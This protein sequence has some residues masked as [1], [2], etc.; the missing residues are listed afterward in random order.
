MVELSRHIDC[1]FD[2][3]HSGYHVAEGE[4]RDFIKQLHCAYGT[5]GKL[6]GIPVPGEFKLDQNL[7]GTSPGPAT[8]LKE[9]CLDAKGRKEYRGGPKRVQGQ[10]LC[11]PQRLVH[12]LGQRARIR[13]REMKRD[14][15]PR[16]R[17]LEPDGPLFVAE[18]FDGVHVG[19]TERRVEAENDADDGGDAE[20]QHGRP[21]R[22]D[23]LHA[24]GVAN[25][26]GNRYAE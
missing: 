15:P 3:G 20:G 12:S 14:L 7:F 21:E 25:D 6:W 5:S 16:G 11:F 10:L 8:Y 19:G 4:R 2:Q 18:G 26:K 23:G 24:G 22:N 13:F 1:V 17:F 9:P